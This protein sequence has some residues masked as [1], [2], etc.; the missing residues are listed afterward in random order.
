MCERLK[1]ATL[2]LNGEDLSLHV[3]GYWID[4][5]LSTAV[6]PE[7]PAGTHTLDISMQHDAVQRHLEWCYLL[8]DFHVQTRG[9]HAHIVADTDQIF[10]GDAVTQGLPFYGGNLDYYLDMTVDADGTYALRCPDF[11][12]P[13]LRVFCDDRDCGAIAYAPYR[14]SLGH[15]SQGSHRLRIRSYGNRVN[16]FGALHNAVDGWRWWGPQSWRL[17]DKSRNDVW[18]FRQTGICRAPLLERLS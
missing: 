3:D 6:L 1:E 11:A 2:Q 12:G 7:L 17:E 16:T 9:A 8:G 13:Q 10:W 5:D 15:L 18:Q 4:R 14:L